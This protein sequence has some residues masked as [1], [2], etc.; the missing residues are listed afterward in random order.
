MMDT[1]KSKELGVFSISPKKT[2]FNF[3]GECTIVDNPIIKSL[4]FNWD[5]VGIG[6]I[7]VE[8]IFNNMEMEPTSLTAIDI[9]S[10]DTD[11]EDVLKAMY[12][13]INKK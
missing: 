2:Y 4:N 13:Q 11:T 8:F 5:D 9:I 3:G 7:T 1:I 10:R 12:K 6:K